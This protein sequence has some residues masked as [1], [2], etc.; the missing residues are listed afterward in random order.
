MF[1]YIHIFYVH[2]GYKIL[3]ITSSVAFQY[4]ADF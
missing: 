1:D 4:C 2:F 3:I